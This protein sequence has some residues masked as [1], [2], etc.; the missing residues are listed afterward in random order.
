M[1]KGLIFLE[2]LIPKE[3]NQELQMQYKDIYP[4]IME[5]KCDQFNT[6]GLAFFNTFFELVCYFNIVRTQDARVVI[7]A[8][9]VCPKFRGFGLG[10][11]LLLLAVKRF[12]ANTIWA[13]PNADAVQLFQRYGFRT[14]GS[15]SD[16]RPIL[17]KD[18]VNVA[19]MEGFLHKIQHK[20]G[21]ELLV[22]SFKAFQK[23][24]EKKYLAIR[25]DMIQSIGHTLSW[26]LKRNP[27]MQFVKIT[28]RFEPRLYL[29]EDENHV[30]FEDD[31]LFFPT[32]KLSR[33]RDTV[34]MR[35]RKLNIMN[36]IAGI[37]YMYESKLQLLIPE[38][39]CIF[40]SSRAY[41]IK[42][43]LDPSHNME[44][45][46]FMVQMTEFDILIDRN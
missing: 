18:D 40:D 32:E 30:I 8:F 13:K 21:E 45:N 15:T 28:D 3:M 38:M 17:Y 10:K 7:Q 22:E 9:E 41:G 34:F 42:D 37:R 24:Y 12:N 11:Q 39:M 44:I 23:N 6:T 19:S 33:R 26:D 1:S 46:I 27:Y 29:S 5:C 31:I 35:D 20:T 16:N 2:H 25:R 43:P 36:A 14:V 4:N